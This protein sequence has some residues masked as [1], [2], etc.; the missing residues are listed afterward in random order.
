MSACLQ[1]HVDQITF[2]TT[3]LDHTRVNVHWD[4]LPILAHKIHWI[5]FVLVRNLT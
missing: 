1:M 2:V 4:L 3:L 5:Q